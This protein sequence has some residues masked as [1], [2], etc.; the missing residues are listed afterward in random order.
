MTEE[1]FIPEQEFSEMVQDDVWETKTDSQQLV[2][3][4]AIINYLKTVVFI[5]IGSII[6]T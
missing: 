1:I 4:L 3:T 2:T 6:C 5:I